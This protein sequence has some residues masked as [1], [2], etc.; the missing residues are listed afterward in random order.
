MTPANPTEFNGFAREM[1]LLARPDLLQKTG[2]G[3]ALTLD[4]GPDHIAYEERPAVPHLDARNGC[5]QPRICHCGTPITR[6]S[7]T[8]QCAPCAR[9][10]PALKAKRAN[11]IRLQA[12]KQPEITALRRARMIAM[13]KSD[14]ARERQR[15]TPPTPT[16]ES[17]AKAGATRTKRMLAHIP[18]ACRDEYRKL[19]K[20]LGA[21]EAARV[22]IADFAARNGGVNL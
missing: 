20:S 6:Q 4:P 7:R 22:V 9:A 16:P 11:A 10:D 15:K 12:G 13:N 19:S 5:T 1:A 8:G 14:E 18:P 2:R 3:S 21:E 17:R